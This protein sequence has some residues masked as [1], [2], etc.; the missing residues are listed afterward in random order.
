MPHR[1]PISKAAL[2]E[3]LKREFQRLKA[4]AC[5]ECEMPMPT[6][7]QATPAKSEWTC[8]TEACEYGCHHA[9][10]WMVSQYSMQY[11][12]RDLCDTCC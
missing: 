1:T 8:L 2:R 4:P 9:M 6:R 7:V 5:V 12:L 11:R 3:I 10:K